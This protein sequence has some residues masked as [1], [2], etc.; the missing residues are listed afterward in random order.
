[1]YKWI[2]CNENILY[3]VYYKDLKIKTI[4]RFCYI[5]LK[6]LKWKT[7][8]TWLPVRLWTTRTCIWCSW[9]YQLGSLL[10]ER[11]WHEKTW[12]YLR[13][14]LLKLKDQSRS[15]HTVW[16]QITWQPRKGR[17]TVRVIKLKDTCSLEEKLWQT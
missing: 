3:I 12:M 16:F 14:V 15:L 17:T 2:I 5:C 9:E 4:V 8:T 11:V 6:W 1:M 7:L 13:Y 10:W